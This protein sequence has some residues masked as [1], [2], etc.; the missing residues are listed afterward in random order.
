M[1]NVIIFSGFIVLSLAAC[2]Q[3]ISADKVPAAVKSGFAKAFPNVSG[4]WE[5]EKG[6]YEVNFTEKGKKMSCLID[7]N[8]SISETE[9]EITVQEMP[10]AARDYISGKYAG[11]KIKE[12]AKIVKANGEVIYEAEL[13]D[14]DLFFDQQGKFLKSEKVKEEDDNN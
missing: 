8:G 13:K 3:K 6:G 12:T 7:A 1:K 5:K 9:T 2:S 10:Q 11:V 4:E 14:H